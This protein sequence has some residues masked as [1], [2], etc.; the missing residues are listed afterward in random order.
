MELY[1]TNECNNFR[2]NNVILGIWYTGKWLATVTIAAENLFVFYWKGLSIDGIRKKRQFW[3]TND[4]YRWN[5]PWNPL[6]LTVKGKVALNSFFCSSVALSL[7]SAAFLSIK[8]PIIFL[9]FI[10]KFVL[11]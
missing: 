3:E 9:K 2:S 1:G 4:N 10:Q 11:I 5:V 8:E 6:Q 7:S